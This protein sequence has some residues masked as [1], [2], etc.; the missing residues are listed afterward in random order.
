MTN[1]FMPQE[2]AP[3][4]QPPAYQPPQFPAPAPAQ[5]APPWAAQ[6]PAQP[7]PPWAAQAPG[8]PQFPAPTTPTPA[9][10]LRSA[11]ELLAGGGK[12]INF[13][14][15]QAGFKRL[16]KPFGGTISGS[17]TTSQVTNFTTK[18]P[19]YWPDGRPREQIQI[20]LDT[21]AGFCGERED[22]VDDGKRT[23]Y[24][25]GSMFAAVRQALNAAGSGVQL[26]DGGSLYGAHTGT[27][28]QAYTWSFLY[29]PAG[30]AVDP[31]AIAAWYAAFAG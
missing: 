9:A 17:P 7:A 24:V 23:L 12:S 3:A 5:P 20:V 28:G 16:K 8:L 13:G 31:A 18:Q 21:T 27:N 6:A 19:E 4:Y 22:E 15:A 29:A 25:K 10:N 2:T 26:R 14:N 1:P 30:Q 11:D